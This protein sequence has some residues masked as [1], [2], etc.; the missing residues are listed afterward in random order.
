MDDR[1]FAD[2]LYQVWSKTTGAQATFWKPVETIN[3]V[4]I[5][6]VNQQNEEKLIGS[7]L[8]S[9]DADFITALHGCLGD[10]VRRLHDALDEADRADRDRDEREV[11]IADL[12]LQV[13][14]L[15]REVHTA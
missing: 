12:E 6:A 4:D 10:L 3:G 7:F 11:R 15:R 14:S 1:S 8:A 13:A 9:E 5:V 2:L